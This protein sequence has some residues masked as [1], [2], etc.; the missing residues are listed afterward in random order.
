M[1]KLKDFIELIS[2]VYNSVSL[3][4][5]VYIPFLISVIVL[6]LIMVIPNVKFWRQTVGYN[7]LG[8]SYFIT[9]FSLIN[10]RQIKDAII[11]RKKL[12]LGINLFF[13]LF[14]FF[15]R[16][17]FTMKTGIGRTGILQSKG[18]IDYYGGFFPFLKISLGY[19][20]FIFL[21]NRK[22]VAEKLKSILLIISSFFLLGCSQEYISVTSDDP[23]LE[24]KGTFSYHPV[25]TKQYYDGDLFTGEVIDY[26]KVPNGDLDP[27]KVKS[28]KLN[29]KRI[30]YNGILTVDSIY[31][32]GKLYEVKNFNRENGI[33]EGEQFRFYSNGKI[34]ERVNIV[35]VGEGSQLLKQFDGEKISYYNSGQLKF[36]EYYVKGKLN[37]ESILYYEN[38]KIEHKLNY[39]NNEF[40][41]EQIYFEKNGEIRKKENFVNGSREGIWETFFENG[42]VKEKMTFLN[43]NL[44]GEYLIYL[45]LDPNNPSKDTIYLHSKRNYKN[46]KQH[47]INYTYYSDGTTIETLYE[48]G[49][50]IS[51][52]EY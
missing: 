40:D 50:M 49:R 51:E 20:I 33:E 39:L 22:D 8:L 32:D 43:G 42:K 23:K 31:Q 30:F 36:K 15:V 52:K 27:K 26:L 1:K 6:V 21:L 10:L 17:M 12:A 47:G 41:G 19:L 11:P 44:N 29:F 48:E 34:E 18:S 7:L 16:H 13:I 4:H 28:D 35:Q 25:F 3:K 24:P 37:G 45:G 14:F 46:H 5:R 2:T 38:G 9:I